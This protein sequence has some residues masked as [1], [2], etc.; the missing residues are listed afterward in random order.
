M[1]GIPV[2]E[3]L[4]YLEDAS[5]AI[6]LLNG[7]YKIQHCDIKP[8]NILLLNGAHSYVTSVWPGA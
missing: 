3:L 7:K 8:Q 1:E 6:D 5:K 2:Q 4:S